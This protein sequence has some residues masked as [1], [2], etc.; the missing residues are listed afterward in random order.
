M[1]KNIAAF[2]SSGDIRYQARVNEA[3]LD[4]SLH[5]QTWCHF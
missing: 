3:P 5:Y 1:M 2:V 4:C